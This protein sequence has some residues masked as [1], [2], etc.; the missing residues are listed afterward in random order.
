MKLLE[1][2]VLGIPY[3]II[4]MLPYAWVG[5]VFF[6]SWQPVISGIFMAIVLL[7]FWMMAWQNRAWEAR[8]TREFYSG[9]ARPY[10][11]HPHIARRSQVL[12]SVLVCIGCGLVGWFLNGLVSL[13]GLQWFLLSAGFMFISRDALI[14]GAPV[15]YIMTNQGI[16]VRFVPGNVDYRLFFKFIE[17]R[18]I[19]RI[20]VPESI[21]R[22]WEVLAPQRHPKEGVML[23]SL[24]RGG[25]SKQIQGEVLLAPTDIEKFLEAPGGHGV[26]LQAGS[27]GSG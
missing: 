20:K 14:F 24:H 23:L 16:G 27:A 5:V 11:D 2:I 8:I 12:H 13:S 6:W 3:Q 22:S 25:F 19:T 10:I 26:M 15:T 1:N 18:Q 9:D 17:I 4:K 7:G 21:P